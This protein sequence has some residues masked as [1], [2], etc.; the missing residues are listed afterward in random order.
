MV[1]ETIIGSVVIPAVIDFFKGAG[2]AISRKWFGESVDDQIK[3]QNADIEKLKALA[4]L[5]NP[6]GTPSQWVI[7]LRASFRYIGAAASML[8]GGACIYAGVAVPEASQDVLEIGF[9][10]VGA[11][12]G[13]IFGERLYL[14][15]K[16]KK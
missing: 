1:F 9:T 11:P 12:F 15:L 3:I 5:D 8:I 10:L 7:D 2:S 4:Q 16:G 6:Y 14:G 13:F